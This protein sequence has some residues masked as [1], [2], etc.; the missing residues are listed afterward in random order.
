MRSG[1]LICL[2]VLLERDL[3]AERFELALEAP[4][5]VLDRVALLLPVG[6]SSRDGTWSRT[7]R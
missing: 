1:G 4:G 2:F 7:M 3:V 5:A 6:P